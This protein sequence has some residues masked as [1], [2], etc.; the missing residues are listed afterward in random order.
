MSL[1]SH[2]AT[3][4]VLFAASATAQAVRVLFFSLLTAIGAQ[5]VIPQEPVP[6]T[7]QTFS[8][9]L[10]GGLLGWRNGSLSMVAYLF[11]G[12]L[13]MPVFSDAGFGFARLLGPTGG[14][15]LAFPVAAIVSGW[16][17]EHPRPSYFR[18][19]F[20][21]SAALFVIF[22]VGTLQ[23]YAVTPL[24][25]GEAFGSGFLIFSLWDIAKLVSA[26]AIVY[27]FRRR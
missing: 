24:S 17:L 21:M 15:L 13:G 6:F 20:A 4:P 26:S 11:A 23:L 9:L 25:L 12:A 14:Y 3:R 22:T 16:I 2:E 18:T 1:P 10:A 7:L 27:G 19:I 8:V 5:I